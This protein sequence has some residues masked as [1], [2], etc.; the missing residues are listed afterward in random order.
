MRKGL[1]V[2]ASVLAL[3]LPMATV[4]AQTAQP[5]SDDQQQQQQPSQP[6]Q[7][8]QQQPLQPQQPGYPGS[9]QAPSTQGRQQEGLPPSTQQQGSAQ[10][11][12]SQTLAVD[13]DALRATE[14]INADVSDSEGTEVATIEDLILSKDGRIQSV[15]LSYGGVLGMGEQRTTVPFTDLT[16]EMGD[17][18]FSLPYT[19]QELKQRPQYRQPG[20]TQ[21][22]R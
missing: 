2:T 19:S 21:P 9:Q 6:M 17:G 5:R 4:S 8:S 10:Q 22:G 7:R 11:Q 15:V 16:V 14:I 1:I 13:Q 3:S 18:G 12:G 20:Q